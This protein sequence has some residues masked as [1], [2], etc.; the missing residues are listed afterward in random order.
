VVLSRTAEKEIPISHEKYYSVSVLDYDALYEFCK[1]E[2]FSG[3]Y[4]LAGY[5]EHSRKNPDVMYKIHID[6]TRNVLK[7]AKELV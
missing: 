2:K 6:G 1:K 7:V 3:I 5:V 4:H